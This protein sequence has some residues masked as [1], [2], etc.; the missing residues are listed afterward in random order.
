LPKEAIQLLKDNGHIL[1]ENLSE[2][3]GE[4]YQSN[5]ELLYVDLDKAMKRSL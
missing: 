4:D 1:D 2:V 3:F 5:K